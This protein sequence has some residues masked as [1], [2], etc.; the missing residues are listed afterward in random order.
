MTILQSLKKLN[1]V[2]GV[3]DNSPSTILEALKALYAHKGGTNSTSNTIAEAIDEVST[4]AG[5]GGG[6]SDFEKI[7]VVVEQV[8]DYWA[9]SKINASYDDLLALETAGKIPY[10]EFTATEAENLTDSGMNT[11]S[12]KKYVLSKVDAFEGYYTSVFYV[13]GASTTG[14][15]IESWHFGKST[16]SAD[17]DAE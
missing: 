17:M 15:T 16:S 14:D 2:E 3:T 10:L 5:G 13:M 6:S 7:T 1:T 4:V 9:V 12:G 11:V 8:D